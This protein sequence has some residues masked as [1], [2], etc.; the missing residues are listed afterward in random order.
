MKRWWKHKVIKDRKTEKAVEIHEFYV[1][2]STSGAL[3]ALCDECSVGDA[4][5]VPPEQ[6]ALVTYIQLRVIYRWIESSLVHFKEAPNGALLVCLRSLTN[7]RNQI[8]DDNSERN[9]REKNT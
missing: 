4:F 3:P 2:R 9:E 6:A 1:V 7:T 5:M 8:M